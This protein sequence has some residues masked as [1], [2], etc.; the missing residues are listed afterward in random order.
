MMVLF[1]IMIAVFIGVNSIIKESGFWVFILK[2]CGFVMLYILGLYF[3]L[4][5]EDRQTMLNS[6]KTMFHK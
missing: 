1:L 5:K 6:V 4:A 2:S 3:V